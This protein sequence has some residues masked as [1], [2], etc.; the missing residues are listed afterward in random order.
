MASLCHFVF[1]RRKDARRTDE[2]MQ[3]EKSKSVTRKDK[4]SAGKDEKKIF[5]RGVIFRPFVRRFFFFFFFFFV[6]LSSLW[7]LFVCFFSVAKRRHTKQEFYG[8]LYHT[9]KTQ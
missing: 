4:I 5:L 8:M 6:F 7:R 9:L 3:R 1:S 2:I